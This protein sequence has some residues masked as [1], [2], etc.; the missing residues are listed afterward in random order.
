M[1]DACVIELP[2]RLDITCVEVLH[3]E[4]EDA[5][6]SGKPVHLEASRVMKLDTAAIQVLEAFYNEASKLHMKVDWL[7]PS[8]TVEEV[9]DFLD[10]RPKVGLNP[11]V[12][13]QTDD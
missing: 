9:F 3:V 11:K 10:L 2:E 13:E 12:Q 4:L 7:R 8:N 1:T 6:A 5:L